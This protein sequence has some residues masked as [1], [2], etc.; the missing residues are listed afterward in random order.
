MDGTGQFTASDF[1]PLL[2]HARRH[3]LVTGRM[4]ER[5][6][7]IIRSVNSLGSRRKRLSRSCR[8]TIPTSFHDGQ[9]R[10]LQRQIRHWR[11]NDRPNREIFPP[12]RASPGRR[13][14][15]R[16]HSH[17]IKPIKDRLFAIVNRW[18]TI[19]ALAITRSR[20][21]QPWL[22]PFQDQHSCRSWSF[23][24]NGRWKRR[25]R[26]GDSCKQWRRCLRIPG[27]RPTHRRLRTWR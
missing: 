19:V 5:S 24:R 23:R 11:G 17:G 3:D 18:E 20:S 4:L 25:L 10:A 7:P 14:R 6:V 15:I 22:H 9:L 1:T 26:L 12:S 13:L 8:R 21:V 2:A 16:F 27:T